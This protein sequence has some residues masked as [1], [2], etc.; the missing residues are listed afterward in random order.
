[1]PQ[2][3]LSSRTGGVVKV[4][5]LEF[6]EEVERLYAVKFPAEYRAFCVRF[7]GVELQAISGGTRPVGFIT[8]LD[9]FRAVNTGVGEGQWGDLERAIVGK[10]HPKDG[11]RLWGAIVPFFFDGTDV[12]AFSEDGSEGEKVLVWAVHCIVHAYPSLLAF[13]RTHLAGADFAGMRD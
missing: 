5:T 11:H 4:P 1:M 2:R 3:P 6:L 8:D 7:Q 12:Y 10:E 9:T 13:A